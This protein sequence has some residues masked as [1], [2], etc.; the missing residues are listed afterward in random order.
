MMRCEE[1]REALPE[2]LGGDL[3][4]AAA[5]R[6]AAHL[7]A[8]AA[9]AAELEELTELCRDVE[10]LPVP[11]PSAEFWRAFGAD[12]ARRIAV[13]PPPRRSAWR[14]L[15]DR[16]DALAFLRPAPALAAAATLGLLLAIGLAQAPRPLDG[17]PVEVVAAGEALGIGMHFELLRDLDLIEEIELPASA[18]PLTS[19]GGAHAVRPA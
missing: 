6:V 3:G 19:G 17:P 16:L 14:W 10:A 9:C 1:V 13:L 2:V 4:E 7:A 5:G 12:L 15:L 8:C 18:S 11:Q